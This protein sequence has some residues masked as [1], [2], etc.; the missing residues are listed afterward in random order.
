MREE[1]HKPARG[2][3]EMGGGNWLTVLGDGVPAVPDHAGTRA[4]WHQALLPVGHSGGCL[5][6]SQTCTGG[7]WQLNQGILRKSQIRREVFGAARG[8]TCGF[9]AASG[10]TSQLVCCLHG[11]AASAIMPNH[12]VVALVGMA[13]AVQTLSQLFP[14][15]T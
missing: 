3:G 11:L 13:R 6:G 10:T 12:P 9:G 2:A 5:A 14:P 15:K 4:R 7:L 8:P 1:T